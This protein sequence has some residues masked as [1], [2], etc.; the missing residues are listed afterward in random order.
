MVVVTP[1]RI[2]ATPAGAKPPC[3]VR[4]E[5]VEPVG[6]VTQDNFFNAALR[7]TTSLPPHDLLQRLLA[8][9]T[10]LFGRTREIPKG[11]RRMDLDLLLYGEQTCADRDLTLP[12][13]RMHERRFVLTPLADIAP[14]LHHPILGRSI[15]DLLNALP[16]TERVTL[17]EDH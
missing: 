12:H 3:A 15:R 2:A 13:P 5:S 11:P 4:L 7:L 1:A 6:E 16:A 8:I 10:T 14:D 17:L 9:E